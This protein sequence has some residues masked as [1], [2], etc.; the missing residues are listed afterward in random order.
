[1]KSYFLRS[2]TAVSMLFLASA[3]PRALADV[4]LPKVIGSQMVLQ[5]DRPLPIWGWADPGEAVRVR[6]DEA[7][8]RATADSQGHWIVVLP[9][10]KADGKTHVL[11]VRGNNEIVLT[12]ILI[13]DV[14]L[15]SGQSNMEMGIT[16]CDT[17][18]TEIAAANCPRIRLLLV[19]KTSSDRPARDVRASW[20]VCSPKTI[21]AGGWGGFSAALYYFGRQLQRELDV[22]VGL[23]EMRLGRLGDRTL[24]RRGKGRRHVQRLDRPRQTARHSGRD[25]VPGR[26]ERLATQWHGLLWKDAGADWGLAA[27]VGL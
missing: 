17:A 21:V 4:R 19:P 2:V 13:G 12:D 11:A 20:A 7:V 25:L 26:D 6:L 10:V 16:R 5:R 1:M 22:P 24:D 9:A 18:A 15:G 8:A 23:V 3:A 27:G 14:W